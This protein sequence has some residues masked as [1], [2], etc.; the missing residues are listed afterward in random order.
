MD[1]RLYGG[2]ATRVSSHGMER[3]RPR[4]GTRLACGE[5]ALRKGPLAVGPLPLAA[6]AGSRGERPHLLGAKLVRA[7]RPDRLAGRKANREVRVADDHRARVERD[8]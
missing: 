1:S 7:L 8:E 4:V 3:G 5:Q 2:R 6:E